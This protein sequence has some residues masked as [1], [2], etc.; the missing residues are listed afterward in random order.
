[1]KHF[2]VW[3]LFYDYDF[4]YKSAKEHLNGKA[5]GGEGRKTTVAS[6]ILAAAPI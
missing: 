1:V 5:K 6:V 3:I 4:S 2:S